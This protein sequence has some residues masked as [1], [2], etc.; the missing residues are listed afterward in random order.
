MDKAAD[1]SAWPVQPVAR[2]ALRCAC[3]RCGAAPLYNGLLRLRGACA[4]CG[5][6]LSRFNVGDG[7]AA[8]II[9]IIGMIVT[10]FAIWLQLSVEPPFWVHLLL[11]LPLTTAGVIMALRISKAALIAL[12][13][14][15]LG[16]G[17]GDRQ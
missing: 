16:V 7:A 5:L 3:P 8:F 6:D 14:R 12:E 10:G 17:G 11:W 4:V 9:L 15:H 1:P 13:Y 2:L